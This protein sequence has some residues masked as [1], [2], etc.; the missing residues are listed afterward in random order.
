MLQ[1]D[2]VLYLKRVMMKLN[3]IRKSL[4]YGILGTF[5]FPISAFAI[6]LHDSNSQ[7]S[8]HPNNAVMGKWSSNASCVAIGN[9]YIITTRHQGG[10]VGTTIIINSTSY[11]VA[12]ELYLASDIRVC[13]ISMPDNQ[14]AYLT[15]FVPISKKIDLGLT[16]TE[17]KIG[18]IGDIRDGELKTDGI[19]YGYLW[20]DNPNNPLNWG[21]NKISAFNEYILQ[22]TFNGLGDGD[23]VNYEAAPADHDS[24]GGWFFKEQPGN[25]W[26]LAG[27]SF[28][29]EHAFQTW[30]RDA[31][32]PNLPHA[33]IFQA[34]RLKPYEPNITPAII[35]PS[36]PINLAAATSPNCGGI[37]NLSW[38]PSTGADGYRVYYRQGAS[39]PPFTLWPTNIVGQTNATITGLVPSQVYYFAVTAY[40]GIAESD[41]SLL[42]AWATASGNCSV[43]ISGYIHDGNLPVQNITVTTDNGGSSNI[44]DA[45]GFYKI[46]VPYGWSGTVM[47]TKEFLSFDPNSRSYS[48][49]TANT[50]NQ[51]FNITI[52]IGDNFDDNKRSA[53]WRIFEDNHSI[54]SIS[55]I[56]NR[57]EMLSAGQPGFLKA[58]YFS[59]SWQLYTDASFSFK[60]NFHNELTYANDARVYIK[61]KPDIADSNYIVFSADCNL[62]TPIFSYKTVVD[63]NV[64]S[65]AQISRSGQG[66]IFYISYDH[67]VDALY[68]SNTSYGSASAWQTIGNLFTSL[69][70]GKNIY[71]EI[72]GG[73]DSSLVYPSS[74][75]LDNFK[76]NTG[77]LADYPPKTDLDKNGFINYGDLN[78]LASQ[79]LKTQEEL[80][81]GE[82]LICDLNG[83]NLVNFDDYAFF[84][85]IW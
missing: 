30:F 35:P 33:D 2:N 61:I 41:Y 18:G 15:N 38:N 24:G 69:W 5:L 45:N 80:P 19:T 70:P 21:S 37:I 13:R 78:V 50:A 54:T 72:G 43:S 66:G 82:Q 42:Q 65:S 53:D 75:Y 52:V 7:P 60:I 14:L 48:N 64:I 62:S 39:G 16:G 79:W 56:N 36:V 17:L 34:H 10:G 74:C 20:A 3:G 12:Q 83:D 40:K 25:V 29:V 8:D 22:G 26:K 58:C 59:N 63:G 44:T 9:R 49:L 6:I 85:Q 27:L 84:A 11:K 4:L 76:I 77:D 47:P 67:T 23:Y 68:L 71:I 55:E 51:N 81:P 32:D 46:T 73:S 31:N 57:L 1:S 28:A